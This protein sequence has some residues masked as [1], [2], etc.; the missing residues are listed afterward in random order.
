MREKYSQ[1]PADVEAV[2]AE[3]ASGVDVPAAIAAEFAAEAPP[4]PEE[5]AK[6]AAPAAPAEP[7]SVQQ[8][9]RAAD[10]AAAAG[11]RFFTLPD[12]AGGKGV[13]VGTSPTIYYNRASGP[14]PGN[15]AV[16]LKA[17]RRGC[18]SPC[19]RAPEL[20]RRSAVLRG[21]A[22]AGRRSGSWQAS[23]ARRAHSPLFFCLHPAHPTLRRRG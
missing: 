22:R 21:A 2:A 19:G 5:A 8:L 7:P 16:A 14:L 1:V 11:Q 6:K 13:P 12:S 18:R 17:R 3:L 20:E 10:A 15:A 9:R 23:L 4:T